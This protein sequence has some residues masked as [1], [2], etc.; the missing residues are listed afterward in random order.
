M[1]ALSIPSHPISIHPSS[2]PSPLP[3]PYSNAA[4]P[5]QHTIISA[6]TSPPLHATPALDRPI[7]HDLSRP[8]TTL[9]TRTT[10]PSLSYRIVSIYI[11]TLPLLLSTSRTSRL[12]HLP[13]GFAFPF[14]FFSIL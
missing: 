13:A 14:S 3:P 8:L 4:S 2:F 5:V 11:S 1:Q 6:A 7:L 12:R 10:P 9:T